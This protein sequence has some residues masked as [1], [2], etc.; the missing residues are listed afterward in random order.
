MSVVSNARDTLNSRETRAVG[1]LF[2]LT[3]NSKATAVPGTVW[4]AEHLK[5]FQEELSQLELLR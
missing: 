4:V 2:P 3:I 5:A 1:S